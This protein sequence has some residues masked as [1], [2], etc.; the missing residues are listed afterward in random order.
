MAD[1]TFVEQNRIQR[2]RL[3]RLLAQ[4][5]DDQMNQQLGD[6]WT[7]GA[8]LA[9]AAFWDAWARQVFERWLRGEGVPAPA[10]VTIV[11]GACD[12]LLRALSPGAVRRLASEVAEAVD[13]LVE[14]LDAD[15]AAE[16]NAAMT[17]V[18]VFRSLHRAEHLDA[19]EQE[20]NLSA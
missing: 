12:P 16:M 1:A 5:R 20:L 17:E 18:S 19:I 7:V 14:S 15:Q 13:R 8:S 2:L 3:Q 10:D 6:G 11:N 9:H 4:L